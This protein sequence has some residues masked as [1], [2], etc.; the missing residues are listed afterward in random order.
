MCVQ[1]MGSSLDHI[2]LFTKYPIP[3]FAKTRMIPSIGATGAATLSSD[4]SMNIISII[5]AFALRHNANRAPAEGDD[6]RSPPPSRVLL[7]VMYAGGEGITDE[8]V[9]TWL[10]SGPERETVEKIS[11][12]VE[13]QSEGGLG[14]RLRRAFETSFGDLHAEKVAAR[15]KGKQK[16]ATPRDVLSSV[17]L[18]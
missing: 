13:R 1:D 2:L 3:G 16:T 7:R 10:G 9:R 4:L 14:I 15:K 6:E 5:R 8:N 18:S 17:C 11:E 12:T